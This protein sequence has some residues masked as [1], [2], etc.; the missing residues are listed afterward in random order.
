MNVSYLGN[1]YQLASGETVVPDIF[2]GEG[3][4]VLTFIGS[5][6]VSVDYRGGSL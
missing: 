4:H 2:I 3:N 5:G 6:T 1:I